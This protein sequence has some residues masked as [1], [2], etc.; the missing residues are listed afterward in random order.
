MVSKSR[1][2]M[3]VGGA[4]KISLWKFEPSMDTWVECP[5][6]PKSFLQKYLDRGFVISPPEPEPEPEEKVQTF[7][8]ALESGRLDEPEPTPAPRKR[9]RR[10]T[11]V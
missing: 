2:E 3:S 5:N 8:E 10:R 4:E 7:S 9:R 11:K 6:L 1:I